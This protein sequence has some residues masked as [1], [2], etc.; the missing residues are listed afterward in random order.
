LNKR[1]IHPNDGDVDHDTDTPDIKATVNVCAVV[2][3]CDGVHDHYIGGSDAQTT[4][5]FTLTQTYR[6]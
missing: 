1:F 2:V 5:L 6:T 3:Q 4:M